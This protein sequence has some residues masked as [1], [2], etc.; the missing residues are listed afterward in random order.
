MSN[1]IRKPAPPVMQPQSKKQP[2]AKENVPVSPGNFRMALAALALIFLLALIV[3][4][5][6]M[7]VILR[8]H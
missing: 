4:G 1:R 3:A 6:S 7:G 5:I 8:R 2:A